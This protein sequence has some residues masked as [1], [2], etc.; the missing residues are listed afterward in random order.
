MVDS[1]TVVVM[2]VLGAISEIVGIGL[3]VKE[4]AADR[5]LA[6]QLIEERTPPREP[7]EERPIKW[8]GPMSRLLKIDWDEVTQ[9]NK[10]EFRRALDNAVYQLIEADRERDD[11]VRDLLSRQLGGSIAVRVRGVLFFAVGIV[12][13][14]GAQILQLA[15][16]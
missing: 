2:T 11:A 3:V 15:D 1:G 5:K 7:P 13:T 16:S 4:V 10:K 9:V 14:T 12:L 6:R 8:W